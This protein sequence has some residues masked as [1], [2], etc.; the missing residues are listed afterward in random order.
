MS[1]ILLLFLKLSVVPHVTICLS[2][3][4]HW[5]DIEPDDVTGRNAFDQKTFVRSFGLVLTSEKNLNR[6]FMISFRKSLFTAM[7]GFLSIPFSRKKQY[8]CN[9]RIRVTADNIPKCYKEPYLNV[10]KMLQ[11]N[12]FSAITKR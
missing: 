10:T 8:F 11:R 9:F 6:L 3:H 2:K 5:S 12:C 4:E 1:R 7:L